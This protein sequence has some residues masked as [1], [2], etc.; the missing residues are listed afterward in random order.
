MKKTFAIPALLLAAA[1]FTGC[2]GNESSAP[3]EIIVDNSGSSSAENSAF[4]LKLSD[5]TV[6]EHAPES[7]AS[8]SPAA[9][10]IISELGFGEKL[11]A[12]SRYCDF[13]EGVCSVTAGSSENPDID[14]LTE[15]APDVLF[16]FTPLAEREKYALESAGVTVVALTPPESIQNYARIYGTVAT[17]FSGLEAG[18]EAAANAEQSLQEA[19]RGVKLGNFVYITPKLTAAGAGT[20]ENAVLSLCGTNMC[21]SDG[22]CE[23][24]DDITDAPDYIIVSDELTEADITGS[25]VF[26]NIAADAEIIFVPSARF[27][28]PSARLA[29]VFTA[30]ESALSGA[31]QTAE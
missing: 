20:F 23:T 21:T 4:P 30:I 17:V 22:Y 25:D 1:L 19:A 2:G 9:T 29:D 28:R 11:C 14:K 10:E 5:G 16:T 3:S 6:I 15:L 8:L 18:A 12:V 26:S 31:Q 7:A 24:F 13:P 27:E